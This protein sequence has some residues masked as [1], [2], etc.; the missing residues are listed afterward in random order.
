M[1]VRI[2][3]STRAL[4]LEQFNTVFSFGEIWL[5]SGNR[6]ANI[7]G[8]TGAITFPSGYV[9]F[10]SLPEVPFTMNASGQLVKN[11]LWIGNR[12]SSF[13]GQAFASF[14]LVDGITNASYWLDGTVSILG[15][16]GALQ[17]PLLVYP[18][19]TQIEVESAL[20]NIVNP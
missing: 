15:G 10:I 3:A 2:N 13:S 12:N 16:S 6:V 5:Y 20:L 9:G 4:M 11:G 7:D 1:N 8:L 14:Q 19:N 18:S 17:F